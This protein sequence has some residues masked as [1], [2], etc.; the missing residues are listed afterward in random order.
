[1]ANVVVTGGYGLIGSHLVTELLKRGDNVT[2]FDIAKNERD[3][4]I[5]F[6]NHSN[7]RFVQGDVTSLSDSRVGLGRVRPSRNLFVETHR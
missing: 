7:F 6:D 3:H 1:M 5:D 2:L 4:S